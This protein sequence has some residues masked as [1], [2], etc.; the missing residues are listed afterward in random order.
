[1]EEDWLEIIHLDK[2]EEGWEVI[3]LEGNP[4]EKW[5]FMFYR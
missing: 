2:D 3:V 1:M 5:F 4:K